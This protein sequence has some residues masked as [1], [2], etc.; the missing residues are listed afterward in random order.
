MNFAAYNTFNALAL[1]LIMAGFFL[2][3]RP[4]LAL[5]AGGGMAWLTNLVQLFI[6]MRRR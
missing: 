5:L 2:Q 4:D 1:L 6:F 3:N